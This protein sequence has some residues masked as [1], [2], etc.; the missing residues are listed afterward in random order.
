MERAQISKVTSGPGGKC[1]T[2]HRPDECDQNDAHPDD[3]DDLRVGGGDEEQARDEEGESQ[4]KEA[5]TQ[6]AHALEERPEGIWG[7]HHWSYRQWI[8]ANAHFA[9]E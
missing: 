4:R 2:P 3:E 7:S 1:L 5:V 6:R 9:L 8:Q